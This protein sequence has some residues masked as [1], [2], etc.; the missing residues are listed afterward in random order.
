MSCQRINSPGVGHAIQSFC[1]MTM[2]TTRRM[3]RG[4]GGLLLVELEDGGGGGF[5]EGGV[6]LLGV[7]LEHF[8]GVALDHHAGQAAHGS[9]NNRDSGDGGSHDGSTRDGGSNDGGSRDGDGRDGRGDNRSGSSGGGRESLVVFLVRLD[10][11]E[12]HPVD[13]VTKALVGVLLGLERVEHGLEERLHVSLLH[14]VGK[15]FSESQQVGG[16]TQPH[17]VR[18][19][20]VAHEA[21][22]CHVRPRT[23]VGAPCHPD[24]NRLVRRK[25]HLVH[26]G[27]KALVDV[28]KAALGFGDGQAAEG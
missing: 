18:A 3:G 21:E 22:L 6:V 27:A 1:R 25:P 15:W 9:G 14:A 20:A 11:L 16:S 12:T 23:P 13:P 5:G 28:W 10:G 24:Q 7:R 19:G 4:R 8:E 17:L 26:G 2:T